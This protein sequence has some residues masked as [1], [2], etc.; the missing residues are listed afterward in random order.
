[1]PGRFTRDRSGGQGGRNLEDLT[2]IGQPI[3]ER[4]LYAGLLIT[5][6]LPRLGAFE[7]K[8]LVASITKN[9]GLRL[10]LPDQEAAIEPA[11]TLRF[12]RPEG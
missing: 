2:V 11:C 6:I 7:V 12:V 5:E 9:F 3:D 10:V 8:T 1:M 4:A